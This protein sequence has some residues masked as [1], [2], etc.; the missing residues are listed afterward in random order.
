MRRYR[1]PLIN[2]EIANAIQC[3]T[4]TNDILE[5]VEFSTMTLNSREIVFG[6]THRSPHNTVLEDTDEILTLRVGRAHD[7]AHAPM[8]AT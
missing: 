5:Y 6:A 7:R 3:R 8:L 4:N 1:T 2:A